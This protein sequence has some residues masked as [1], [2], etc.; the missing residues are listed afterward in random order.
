MTSQDALRLFVR[1][2]AQSLCE[3]C[4]SSEEAS[5][6]LFAMDHILPRSLGGADHLANL[7]LACQR[8]NGYRDNFTTAVDPQT[9]AMVPLFNPRTQS[10][11]E[12]FVWTADGLRILG[13]S[14]VGRATCHRLDYNDERHN[15]GAIERC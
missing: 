2:R 8:C 9:Q 11:A 10:W 3:Y 13:I 14:P 12:H 6:A 4:H 7:A 1:A 15:D 5:A